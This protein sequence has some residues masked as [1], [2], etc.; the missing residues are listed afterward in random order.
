MPPACPECGAPVDHDG[1]LCLDCVWSHVPPT[2]EQ[3]P[4][5]GYDEDGQPMGPWSH[6]Q[7]LAD[8]EDLA[9]HP[10]QEP[11]P[12]DDPDPEPPAVAAPQPRTLDDLPLEEQREYTAW[13]ERQRA[14]GEP[15]PIACCKC[16]QTATGEAAD[17]L[18]C[19][20]CAAARERDRS[21]RAKARALAKARTTVAD[22]K[23]K[24]LA[25]QRRRETA[26]PASANPRAFSL[27]K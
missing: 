14:L 22:S 4:G 24:A 6:G 15:L 26:A 25:E 18:Y 23:R 11:D 5:A 12:D 27:Y 19:D 8:A 17:G 2:A 20:A 13:A 3:I 16:G 21:Q 9:R 7:E 10:H 1:D